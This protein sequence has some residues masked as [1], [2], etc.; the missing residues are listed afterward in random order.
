MR[1]AALEKARTLRVWRAHNRI[2][3]QN[4]STGCVCDEQ[5][6]RFRK[7]QR[8]AGCSIGAHCVCKYHKPF[9]EPTL[10]EARANLS[11]REWNC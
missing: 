11:H 9:R 5:A 6:G 3:H 8:A 1:R 2:I 7:G 10:Q 4:E